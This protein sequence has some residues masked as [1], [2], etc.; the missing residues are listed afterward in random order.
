M[1][2]WDTNQQTEMMMGAL[3]SKKQIS[4]ANIRNVVKKSIWDFF[5]IDIERRTRKREVVEARYMYYEICR[6]RRMS[7]N[8][9]GQ[10]VGKDHATVLHGTKRFKILCEVDVNFRENFESL[11]TI[12]DF[13]SSRKVSPSMSGKSLSHQLADALNLIEKLENEIDDLRMQMLKMQI[14]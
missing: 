4:N 10:S 5:K 1:L 3:L 8:E 2:H 6:M 11:K 9:I 12:V 14:Q 13:R 7:L